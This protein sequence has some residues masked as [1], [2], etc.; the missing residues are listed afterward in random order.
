M[1]KIVTIT[2][3]VVLLVVSITRAGVQTGRE[4]ATADKSRYHRL[5]REIK[6]VEA[7][8]HKVQNQ[9]FIEA[10]SEGKASLETKSRLLAI[11]DKRRRIMDRLLLMSLRHGWDIPDPEMPAASGITQPLD[12]K[13]RV[14]APADEI[15]KEKFA[16]EA[17]RIAA[18]VKLPVISL[19]LTGPTEQIAKGGRDG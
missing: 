8:Y 12:D 14:F 15:I 6:S 9:A 18:Q 17:H 5:L 3:G 10:K 16:Q 11:S 1:K 7:D 13:E 19:P 2:F 4:D